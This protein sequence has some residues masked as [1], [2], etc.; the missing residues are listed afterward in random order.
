[1]LDGS[2]DLSLGKIHIDVIHA[3]VVTVVSAPSVDELAEVLGTHIETVDFVGDIHQDLRTFTGLGILEN[4]IIIIPGMTDVIK[5]DVD[6]IADIDDT[7]FRTHLLCHDD[8]IGFCAGGGAEARNGA[9]YNVS[10]RK[11]HAFDR[12]CTDHNGKSGVNTAGD[13][14]DAVIQ[15]GIF[16][17]FHQTGDLN[18]DHALTIG[19]NILCQSRQMRV[20][21]EVTGQFGNDFFPAEGDGTMIIGTVKGAVLDPHIGK[22]IHV[23]LCHGKR[24]FFLLIC[25]N[26]AVFCHEAKPGENLVRCGFAL[27]GRG[28]DHTRK[29]ALGLVLYGSFRFV[30]AAYSHGK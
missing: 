22:V 9:C 23:Q 21:G 18:V 3:G 1:M 7:D 16:H 10:G 12:L 2:T 15:P 26:H 28:A 17:A 11:P 27:V 25:Q 20:L 13:T 24:V 6:C 14:D 30:P 8:G 5:M 19:R 29:G 4:D